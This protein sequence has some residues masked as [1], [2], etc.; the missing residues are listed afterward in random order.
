MSTFRRTFLRPVAVV[1][2]GLVTATMLQAPATASPV[3]DGES[4]L[5]KQLTSNLV[6]GEYEDSWTDPENPVWVEYTDHGLTADV[7]IALDAIGGNARKVRRIAA[8]LR[9]EVDAWT[10]N[11]DY[12]GS[13]AKAVV[14]AVLGKK[15]PRDFGGVDL[16]AQL[17]ERTADAAPITGRIEDVGDDYSNTIGQ[18]FAALALAST[19]SEE[20]PAARRFLLDQQC[21][22]G[23]FRLLFSDKSA[24]DQSCDADAASAPDTDVTALSVILLSELPQ[25]G[26]A[27]KRATRHALGWLQD[28]QK[29]NGSFGGGTSTEGSNSNSTGLAAWALGDAGRCGAAEKAA[30]WVRTL[31]VR[32]RTGGTPMAG[33]KGAIAYDKA[34]Y[35]AGQESG[36][37]RVG[38]DQWRRATSQAAPALRYVRGC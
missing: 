14:T 6:V 16:V 17:E 24:E 27:V 34:G 10:G 22:D 4:W 25:Q 15:D 8:A 30:D 11:G 13:V 38:R 31:Q 29:R 5:K 3:G 26:K 23:S 9:P 12:A 32:G 18:A 21:A 35:A 1:A 20:A 28:A 37:T 19:G 2:A 33:E 36:I 7:A